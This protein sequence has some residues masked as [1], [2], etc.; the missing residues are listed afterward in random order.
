MRAVTLYESVLGDRFAA[1]PPVLRRFHA[2]GDARAHGILRVERG[3]GPLVRLAAWIMNM[4]PASDHAVVELRVVVEDGR[5]VWTRSFTIPGDERGP[6]M[7]TR[8]WREDGYLVE[9]VGPTRTYFELESEPE[10]MCFRQRRCTI[11]GIPIPRMLAPHV[12]AR[13]SSFDTEGWE[14]EVR[15][16]LPVIGLLVE[17]AG[18]LIPDP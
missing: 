13:A 9:A 12:H 6:P 14:V 5:E 17:Y 1:L 3:R 16:S 18:R 10:G 15:I 11:L 8:Q 2:R 7:I 4:P